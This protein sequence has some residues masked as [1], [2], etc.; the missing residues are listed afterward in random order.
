M[1]TVAMKTLGDRIRE[2]REGKDLSLREFAKKLDDI[3]PAHISDIENNRR[4]PSLSLL[5][6][7][8]RALDVDVEDLQKFDLRPPMGDLK[9]IARQN[10]ALGIALRTITEKN[11]SAQD[12]ID[13]GKGKS[14]RDESQ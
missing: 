5:K 6:L 10:P 1:L 7:M 14:K 3:S 13:L 12:I 2:L 4:F 8:A 9:R 11:I